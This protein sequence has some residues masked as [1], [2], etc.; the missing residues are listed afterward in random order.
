MPSVYVLFYELNLS[1]KLFV[2][3]NIF[4]TDAS[5]EKLISDKIFC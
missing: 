3:L 5:E 1:C 4:K 2:Y